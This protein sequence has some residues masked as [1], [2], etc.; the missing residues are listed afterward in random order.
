MFLQCIIHIQLLVYDTC[1]Q[2]WLGYA[3]VATLRVSHNVEPQVEV[4]FLASLADFVGF[5]VYWS[6]TVRSTLDNDIHDSRCDSAC[7]CHRVSMV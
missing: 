7:A 1:N 2:L 5:N 4:L 6:T 3:H